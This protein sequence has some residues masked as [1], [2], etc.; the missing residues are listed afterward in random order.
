MARVSKKQELN[1]AAKEVPTLG[2]QHFSSNSPLNHI[3]DE[4]LKQ[5]IIECDDADELMQ[6]SSDNTNNHLNIGGPKTRFLLSGLSVDETKLSALI[7]CLLAAMLFGGVNYCF[8]GDIS[9]NLTSII[10]TLIYTIAGVNITS[11]ILGK[12]TGPG[13]FI[14]NMSVHSN[15]KK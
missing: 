8:N 12:M 14:N 2:E 10:T 11:N 3:K 15:S 1:V 7:I 13:G 4:Q 6:T 9:N 5:D